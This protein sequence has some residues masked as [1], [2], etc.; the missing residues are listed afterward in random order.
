MRK[1][2]KLIRLGII[3]FVNGIGYVRLISFEVRGTC[4]VHFQGKKVKN[5]ERHELK[6]VA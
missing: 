6:A 2:E 4:I 5:I 3:Y 1:E